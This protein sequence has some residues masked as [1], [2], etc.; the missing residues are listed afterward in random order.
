MDVPNI[1]PLELRVK[2][3]PGD[4]CNCILCWIS[5][6]FS[7]PDIDDATKKTL[8]TFNGNLVILLVMDN[9]SSDFEKLLIAIKKPGKYTANCYCSKKNDKNTHRND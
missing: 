8:L 7:Q 3:C 2:A 9:Q 1:Q 4:L 5:N 6:I